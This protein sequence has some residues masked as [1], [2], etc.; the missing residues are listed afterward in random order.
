MIANPSHLGLIAL[1]F[2]VST[3]FKKGTASA[4]PT[5]LKDLG[6]LDSFDFHLGRNPLKDL[7]CSVLRPHSPTLRDSRLQQSLAEKAVAD[8]LDCK[9]FPLSLGGEHTVSLG[10]IMAAKKKIGDLGIVQLDAHA[11]LRNEYE[12]NR[13]SH[14]CVMRRALELGCT[15]LG[16]GIRTLCNE[17]RELI[18]S[19]NLEMVDGRRATTS[20]EWYG[21]LNNLPDTVYLTVD[22]DVFDPSEVPSVGTPEPGGP[23][24][25]P[26]CDFLHHL[27]KV[28]NVVAADIVELKPGDDDKASVRLA[29]RLIGLIAGLR[30][31]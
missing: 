25:E 9:G 28:K 19:R 14:A 31:G 23:G 20:T 12:N 5:I 30:F 22:M 29:S 21:I 11:D 24:F 2:E 18:E 26:I 7:P 3:S 8:L 27:F 17:E 4:P 10:P 1:P 6:S 15:P 16:I 13:Y